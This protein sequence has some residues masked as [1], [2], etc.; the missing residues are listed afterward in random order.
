M[1]LED[2]E[3]LL[4]LL[5]LI[6]QKMCGRDLGKLPLQNVQPPLPLLLRILIVLEGILQL[7]PL[8]VGILIVPVGSYHLRCPR[9][10]HLFAERDG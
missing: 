4:D 7:F 1:V 9:I 3:L 8:P 6:R 5:I 2:G 10:H